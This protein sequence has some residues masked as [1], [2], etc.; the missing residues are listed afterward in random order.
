MK[1]CPKCARYMSWSMNFN[2]GIPCMYYRCIC[3][4]DTRKEELK[5]CTSN[6]TTIK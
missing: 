4:Y 2:N 6:K 1:Q 3:G 5:T